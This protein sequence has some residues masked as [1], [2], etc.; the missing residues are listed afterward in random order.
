MEQATEL[1]DAANCFP[2]SIELRLPCEQLCLANDSL[3]TR[4]RPQRAMAELQAFSQPHGT[5]WEPRTPELVSTDAET[6]SRVWMVC[7]RCISR[8]VSAGLSLLL[9]GCEMARHR[10]DRTMGGRGHRDVLASCGE[11]VPRG[12]SR[13]QRQD[14]GHGLDGHLT[15]RSRLGGR[16][17]CCTEQ[18]GI[19]E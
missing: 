1:E 12:A 13:G 2:P 17:G 4:P 9:S 16:G 6:V 5:P 10:A 8:L 18:V 15:R 7:A 14:E 11:S 3:C 19:C